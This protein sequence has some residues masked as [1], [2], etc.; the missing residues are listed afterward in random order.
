MQELKNKTVDKAYQKALSNC[1][2]YVKERFGSMIKAYTVHGLTANLEQKTLDLSLAYIHKQK[3]DT[4]IGYD[5]YN[6]HIVS[7]LMD[8]RK[9]LHFMLFT[10]PQERK[11]PTLYFVPK[12]YRNHQNYQERVRKA[13]LA[14]SWL[15]NKK[16]FKD[17]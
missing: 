8:T 9:Q 17:L 6:A 10:T 11:D 13:N 16:F 14:Y 5:K 2:R 3:L 12:S 4:T 7:D 15:R 1:R